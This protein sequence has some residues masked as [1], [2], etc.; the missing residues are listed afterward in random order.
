[1]N[2]PDDRSELLGV[3]NLNKAHANDHA[4]VLNAVLSHNQLERKVISL[5]S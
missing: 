2:Y 3:F 4:L 5:P 1:M